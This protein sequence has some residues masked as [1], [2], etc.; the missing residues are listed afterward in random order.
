MMYSRLLL[1]VFLVFLLGFLPAGSLAQDSPCGGPE[2][3]LFDFWL[4]SWTVYDSLDQVVGSN[5]IIKTQKGCLLVENWTSAR[6][7]TGTSYNYYQARD[8]T[9]NQ[10][11]IDDQGGILEL[12]GKLVEGAMVLRGELLQG[13]QNQ[14]Y[15]HRITWEPM[16]G[17]VIQTWEVLD[18][19]H[20]VKNLLFKGFYRRK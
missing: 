3:A 18:E 16:D 6:G 17:E 2:H 13:Q 20:V 9:W 4:G 14:V 8:S 5:E 15:Y 1:S 12:K 11:W 10:L 7:N 19:K